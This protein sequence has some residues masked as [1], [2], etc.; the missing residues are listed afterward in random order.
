[1]NIQRYQNSLLPTD[2]HQK[3]KKLKKRFRAERKITVGKSETQ[4]ELKKKK[5]KVISEHVDRLN[6]QCLFLK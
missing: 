6:Q 2:P 1:M 3:K 5:R 4:K